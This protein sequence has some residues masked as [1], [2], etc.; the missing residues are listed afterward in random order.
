MNSQFY[1]Q[2]LDS[3]INQKIL[4]GIC[5][6]IA[7]YKAC[8]L[9]RLL[10]KQG[11]EVRV[12]MTESATHFVQPLTF[13]ALSGQ[14]VHTQILDTDEENAM[15]H[16][17]LARWADH[18][19][20]APATANMIA[21]MAHGL[22]D[23]LLSTL[24]LANKSPVSIAPA[25]N[26][27]MWNKAVT[28]DNIQ[29]LKQQGVNIIGP[30]SGDQACGDTG[31]GRMSEAETICSQILQKTDLFLQGKKILISAG[32]TREALDPVRYLTNRSSGKMGYALAQ[33]A[34]KAGAE[35]TLVTGPVNIEKPGQINLIAVESAQEMYDAIVPIASH[36][37]IFIG[38][39]AVADYRPAQ[40]ENNKIKKQGE[41][42]VIHLQ[43]N[44][45]IIA[46]VAALKN[47]P[48]VVGFA[49]ETQDLDNY[50]QNK[51]ITKKMDMIAANWVGRETGGF[52]SDQN[53]LKVF[54]EN[55]H[56]NLSMTDKKQL[57]EQL[58]KLI[59]K[60]LNEKSTT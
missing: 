4:L 40:L 55:G 32:P 44:P 2:P 47:K 58:L 22:A 20:I 30:E 48:F 56:Q 27:A 14:P 35:V 50:A 43:R 45:D 36:F 24:Y 9:V 23:D 60:N 33:A 42:S 15:G 34:Q 39:A 53:A 8:E 21:K 31:F 37:D 26:Q 18:F 1:E 7:A 5:G 3:T 17:Q 41:E 49:A 38:A 25:M 57:A 51:R 16:I 28:Q 10:R 52:D 13:Q 6:G 46:A 29:R 54:W 11:A 19:I 12:V 59:A